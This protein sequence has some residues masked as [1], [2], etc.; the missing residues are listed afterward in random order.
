MRC[1]QIAEQY[2]G[3]CPTQ[4]GLVGEAEFHTEQQRKIDSH[5]CQVC[6][7]AHQQV[8]P[9]QGR[10]PHHLVQRAQIKPSGKLESK[11]DEHIYPRPYPLRDK[12]LEHWHGER[13][14]LCRVVQFRSYQY[15][16]LH[17]TLNPALRRLTLSAS[18]PCR[19]MRMGTLCST[20]TKF[21]VALSCGIKENAAPV[22]SDMDST[23]PL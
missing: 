17:S 23:T 19:R 5:P 6:V 10:F 7:E 2:P 15:S 1:N 11:G 8:F 18:L 22:A 3:S 14:R 16:T 4:Q 13:Y 21:P 12:A 9:H 20:L